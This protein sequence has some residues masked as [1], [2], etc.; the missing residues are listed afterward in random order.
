MQQKLTWLR[1]SLF[2]KKCNWHYL[3]VAI[4]SFVS[5]NSFSVVDF[6]VEFNFLCGENIRLAILVS[7]DSINELLSSIDDYFKRLFLDR[8]L[9]TDVISL[10]VPGIFKPFEQNTIQYGLFEISH[11]KSTNEAKLSTNLS[12]IIVSA[13][14]DDEIDD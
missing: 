1:I 2:T 11:E 14:R 3:L 9:S 13:L 5:Q 12:R 8:N 4:E 7:E 6:S 10:P